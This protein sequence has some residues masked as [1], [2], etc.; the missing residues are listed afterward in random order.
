[1]T[2]QMVTIE[3]VLESDCMRCEMKK[4]LNHPAW[5]GSL[6]KRAPQLY[7]RLLLTPEQIDFRNVR[8]M[9]ITFSG[10]RTRTRLCIITA[11]YFKS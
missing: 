10:S 5:E 7:Q 8:P 1:M 4:L 2:L 3:S 11:Y 6:C 9:Q